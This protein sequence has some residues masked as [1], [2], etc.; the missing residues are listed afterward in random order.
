MVA[1][2][3]CAINRAE[4]FAKRLHNA[5]AGF[6]T[7]DRA[8][9]RLVATR[10]EIDMADIKDA[11]QQKYGKSLKSMIQGDTSGDYKHALYVL[12][13]EKKS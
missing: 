11:Y 2:L 12:I 13:G 10:C 8:L 9:I 5:M 3:R 4:Y 7:D 1:I 6:G